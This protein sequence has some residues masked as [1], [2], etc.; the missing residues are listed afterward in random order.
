VLDHLDLDRIR[1]PLRK[2]VMSDLRSLWRDFHRSYQEIGAEQSRFDVFMRASAERTHAEVHAALENISFKRAVLHMDIEQVIAFLATGIVYRVFPHEGLKTN[3]RVIAQAEHVIQAFIRTYH[4]RR[5]ENWH[6]QVLA[7]PQLRL[8]VAPPV[9]L[10]QGVPS[11]G[12]VFN[13]DADQ[14]MSPPTMPKIQRPDTPIRAADTSKFPGQP[15]SR[16]L[17]SKALLISLPIG[18]LLIY[19][20]HNGKNIQIPGEIHFLTGVVVAALGSPKLR[21]VALAFVAIVT[22]FVVIV[23]LW[24]NHIIG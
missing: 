3:M 9:S 10:P 6:K 20:P 16:K 18:I 7:D 2:S 11:D 8:E 14:A 15:G 1:R 19:F 23:T 4:R 22:I 13:L 12:L 24:T 21:P 5:I 17:W